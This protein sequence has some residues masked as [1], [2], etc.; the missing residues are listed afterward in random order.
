[1]A[2]AAIGNGARRYRVAS[3]LAVVASLAYL[4]AVSVHPGTTHR[5][6]SFWTAFDDFGQC[7]TPFIAAGACWLTARRS[8]GRERVSWV[9]IGLGA[10]SWGTGQIVWTIYEV[11]LG[12]QPVSPSAC[13]VGFLLSPVLIAIGLLRFVDTPAGRLSQV[14]GVLEAL[15]ISAGVL[16]PVWALLLSPV[17]ATSRNSLTE[18]LVTLAYPMLDAVVIAT[19]LFMV[20]RRRSHVYGRL[21]LL[22][23]AIVLLAVSDSTFWYLTTV[24]NLDDVNPTDAGWFA[25]FLLLGFGAVALRRS[26]RPGPSDGDSGSPIDAERR[27]RVVR[28]SWVVAAAPELVALS[29]LLAVAGYQLIAGEGRFDRP[30]S[31]MVVGL[32]GLALA[33]GVSVVVENHVLTA[34]LED[35]VAQRTAELVA[36]ERHFAALVEHSS[37]M[38]AVI[39]PDLTITWMS[40]SVKEAHGWDPDSLI[41]HKLSDFGDRYR[42]LIDVLQ[43]S[44]EKSEGLQH[45][46]WELVDASGRQQFAN[47]MITNLVGDPDVG[48]YVINTRDVTD[49]TLLEQEL[50]HQ[51]F[52][53]HLSG[54][55][56]RA[57]F[58]DRAEHALLRARRTG[59]EIA[60][61][62]IDLDGFKDVND[63]LGHHA[64]DA[65]LRT[66][67]RRLL[68]VAR[69]SDTV[70]RLGGDEFAVLMEDLDGPG[71]ALAAAER[72]RANLRDVTID[73]HA[74]VAIT[75]SIGVAISD[76]TSS[77][78][79]LLRDADI[80]MYS[81]KNNGKD[82]DQLFEPWMRTQARERFELQ[83]E[84]VGAL[85]RGEFALAYQ[86]KFELATG[87][88]EGFEALLRWT[89]PSLGPVPPDKFI[90]LAEESG[91]IVPL[92]RWVLYEATRQL[93]EWSRR[94]AHDVALTMAVN[95]SARQMRDWRLPDDVHDAIAAAGIAPEHVVLEITESMLLHDPKEVAV[96]LRALKARGVRIA[97][98][99]FG[100]GYSSL[101]VLQD[102]PIDILKIDKAFVSPPAESETNGDKVLGAILTLAQTLGLRTVA[103]GV[104]Q[105]DQ[106]A[107]LTARGCDIGQGF[108]WGRP[109]VPHDAWTLV[110]TLD[111]ELQSLH[112]SR[113]DARSPR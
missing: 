85:D 69:A 72:M 65:L 32:A 22:A 48:G 25:G 17:V 79:D 81:V 35:R 37:D 2:N 44:P 12:H 49:Q 1:M 106:A 103:E 91:L 57:L 109:L 58:N 8:S 78:S 93:G 50:R 38:T 70:A 108:L 60:V 47:S 96:V 15:L 88:L 66:T 52:H 76:P 67:A 97:I 94:L 51:A 77:V 64:G 29:G 62:M 90:T 84:L 9:L 33:H 102:L 98:D 4:V 111:S 43:Q 68:D 46:A 19:V 6:A 41:G 16:V 53:D 100:T 34:T 54:L 27:Q 59:T 28:R 92:G 55:A 20:T 26:N 36:R 82:N 95:V 110:A 45:A 56:N 31:W 61:M 87:H 40:Q 24:K 11:G 80:A 113:T 73:A 75:A 39:A 63:G 74:D 3:V 23:C 10:A 30:V 104:E 99:D 21:S 13:D 112:G 101:S 83:S 7:I 105:V 107:L 71:D 5:W 42:A 86:P 89:H 18:Q 14:R